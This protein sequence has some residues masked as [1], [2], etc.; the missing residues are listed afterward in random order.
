MQQTDR[1]WVVQRNW[2]EAQAEL[3]P[4]LAYTETL[5]PILPALICREND[6]FFHVL[7]RVRTGD[8]RKMMT[9]TVRQHWGR[10]IRRKV[11][12][13]SCLTYMIVSVN[14]EGELVVLALLW[15][16]HEDKLTSDKIF[17]ATM[18]A[19]LAFDSQVAVHA[20]ENMVPCE[21]VDLGDVAFVTYRN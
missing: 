1:Q 19:G 17:W 8:Y 5:E 13:D 11:G 9:R 6:G 21:N 2:Q 15:V 16:T 18:P 20:M 3:R 14:P 7:Q 4:A 10:H 12:E